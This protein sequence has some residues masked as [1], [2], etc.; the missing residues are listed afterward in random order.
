M[1]T[2]TM[3]LLRALWLQQRDDLEVPAA[4][5]SLLDVEVA[6]WARDV[7]EMA[8]LAFDQAGEEPSENAFRSWA[9]S[10]GNR[11]LDRLLD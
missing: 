2:A 9:L 6:N 7:G 4:V 10:G 3:S 1:P 8:T 11:S 5:V